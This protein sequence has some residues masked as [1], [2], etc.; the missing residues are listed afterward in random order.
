MK[1]IA[2]GANR[3]QATAR[4]LEALDRL[5]I[6]GIRTNAAFVSALLVDARF[7]TLQH[8]TRMLDRG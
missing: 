3:E 8:D 6:N 2:H 7:A 1:L 5:Q 4:L